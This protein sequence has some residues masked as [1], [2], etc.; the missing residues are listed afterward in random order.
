MSISARQPPQ[1]GTFWRGVGTGLPFVLVIAP[2]GMLFG[3]VATEA[4]LSLA[5]TMAM[6]VLVIA[7][8]AQFTAVALM[9]EQAPSL[10]VIATALAVNLRMALYSASMAQHL[11]TISLWKRA[12]VAYLLVDQSY[13]ASIAR[14]EE[15]PAL[16][17]AQKIAFFFGVITPIAPLWYLF[18]YVG[19]VAGEAIP[20]EYALDFAV[21]I[22]FIALVAPLLRTLPHI[23]TALVSVILALALA[24][25]PYALGLLVAAGVAMVSGALTEWRLEKARA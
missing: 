15:T 3:V 21:P 22:T 24:W 13:A 6:T 17:P 23:V 1:Q 5:E 20:P 16:T 2:F 12:L 9:E 4:G 8:A 10:I 7:G 19:A 25:V 14:Y 18:T 11:G